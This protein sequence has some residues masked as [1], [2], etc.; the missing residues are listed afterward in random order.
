[1]LFDEYENYE[2]DYII[3]SNTDISGYHEGH[4]IPIPFWYLGEVRLVGGNASAGEIRREFGVS[5]PAVAERLIQIFDKAELARV[6]IGKGVRLQHDGDADFIK[7]IG[8]DN[9]K[10][11][12]EWVDRYSS[13]CRNLVLRKSL[14]EI[15][16]KLRDA[17]R[18]WVGM[19]LHRADF[20]RLAE[21]LGNEG[22]STFSMQERKQ[23]I[24]AFSLHKLARGD[25]RRL[26]K[27]ISHPLYTSNF[28]SGLVGHYQNV[29]W[30]K[31]NS[32]LAR[33]ED[34][35]DPIRSVI[36]RA[37]KHHGSVKDWAEAEGMAAL[38]FGR[39]DAPIELRV[40]IERDL[41]LEVGKIKAL[42]RNLGTRHATGRVSYNDFEER[43][44]SAAKKIVSMNNIIRAD[45]RQINV[46][47]SPFVDLDDWLD[48]RGLTSKIK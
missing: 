47:I 20:E 4:A 29:G 21:V 46:G 44:S 1:M 33:P 2:V 16:V 26:H 34:I 30:P 9:P 5:V 37:K 17:G 36:R 38:L 13:A 27:H 6:P 31:T 12:R 25:F 39:R 48:A 35:L 23:I 45:E 28:P 10:Y 15:S 18:Q 32:D 11:V 7:N 22:S 42:R 40:L 43:L 41:R 3:P 14:P 24:Y 19:F 8:I